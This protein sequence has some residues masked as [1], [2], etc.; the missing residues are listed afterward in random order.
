MSTKL[1]VAQSTSSN[2]MQHASTIESVKEQITLIQ[3][4]MSS[5][6]QSDVHYGVI[7]GTKKPTLLKPGAEKLTSTFRLAPKYRI[8]RTDLPD[9]HREYE[10]VCVLVSVETGKEHGEGV[11]CCSTM[12]SK[13]RW[14]SGVEFEPIAGAHIPGDYNAKKAEYK[15]QGLGARK[16][17][18]EWCWG[19]LKQGDRIP[20][21]DIADVFNTVMKMAAKRALVSATL[22]VTAA[23]DI[24]TQDVEDFQ[25][26]PQSAPQPGVHVTHLT[27]EQMDADVVMVP[28]AVSHEAV[29]WF[30]T[31]CRSIETR[32]KGAN[33]PWHCDEL[34]DTLREHWESLPD[35]AKTLCVD[36]KNRAKD[37][38][39]SKSKS[40]PDQSPDNTDNSKE[41]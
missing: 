20:N 34:V 21:P 36:L 33:Q 1:E 37:A 24:F 7:P 6:M 23:S 9:G 10:I 29:D 27:A 2:L 25:Q 35:A 11:G 41:G 30:E 26:P 39:D 3:H 19:R 16:V 17:N 22:T 18:D 28:T 13:Y 5:A 12:E 38:I 4:C 32:L 15:R 31:E 8:N 40:L 14:R